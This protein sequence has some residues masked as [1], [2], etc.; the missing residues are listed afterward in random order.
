MGVA[1]C[2]GS[3]MD[4]RHKLYRT[5]NWFMWYTLVCDISSECWKIYTCCFLLITG[6]IARCQIS[7]SWSQVTVTGNINVILFSKMCLF[8]YCIK[9]VSLITSYYS[10]IPIKSHEVSHHLMTSFVWL[11]WDPFWWTVFQLALMCH[12]CDNSRDPPHKSHKAFDIYPTMH[13]L[14]T[15]MSTYV[16]ISVTWWCSVGYMTGA[17]WNFCNKFVTDLIIMT[18]VTLEHHK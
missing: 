16:H 13:H 7:C 9:Y 5:Q 12:I 6:S 17:L 14:V 11:R 15:E 18:W 2:E 1:G 8:I 4:L 10:Y 3:L